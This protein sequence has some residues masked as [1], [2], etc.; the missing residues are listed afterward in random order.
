METDLKLSYWYSSVW[1]CGSVV[2]YVMPCRERVCFGV[3]SACQS[4]QQAEEL[5][6]L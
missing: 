2:G 1:Q 6:G 4:A 3:R 5:A